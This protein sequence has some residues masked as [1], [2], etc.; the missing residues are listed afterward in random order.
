MDVELLVPLQYDGYVAFEG[1]GSVTIRGSG[2]SVH[3]QQPAGVSA[4]P[5]IMADKLRPSNFDFSETN[6][7]LELYKQLFGSYYVLG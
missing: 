6:F 7:N 2:F 5:C 1:N 3:I 4:Q